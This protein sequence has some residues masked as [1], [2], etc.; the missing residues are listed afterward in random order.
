MKYECARSMC[1]I[2]GGLSVEGAGIEAP[3]KLSSRW[4]IAQTTPCDD[5]HQPLRHLFPLH[6]SNFFLRL[7]LPEHEL[8]SY[9]FAW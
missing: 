2:D 9:D 8:R 1:C 7:T 6:K 4:I 3:Q 5:N